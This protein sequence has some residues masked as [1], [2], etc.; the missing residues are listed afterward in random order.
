[1]KS[2]NCPDLSEVFLCHLGLS[3]HCSVTLDMVEIC[4][5]SLAK[6][7]SLILGL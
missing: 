7:T 6:V 5:D 1:M 3:R 2:Q 4:M